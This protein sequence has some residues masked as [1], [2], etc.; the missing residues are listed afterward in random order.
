MLSAF[1][2]MYIYLVYIDV[3]FLCKT[4]ICLD[5]SAICFSM[6]IPCIYWCRVQLKSMNLLFNSVCICL[7]FYILQVS[8]FLCICLVYINVAFLCKSIYL[9]FNLISI[10]FNLFILRVSMYLVYIELMLPF[11]ASLRICFSIQFNLP[12]YLHLYLFILYVS[13]Y[14]PCVYWCC[15]SMQI[16][17]FVA[18]F[19]LNLQV[20]W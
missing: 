8:N 6:Y 9:L 19:N 4:C 12:P 17:E 11:C 1:F 20:L 10:C 13:M 2:F 14:I 16:Y 5:F 18:L 3:A 7:D 15:I